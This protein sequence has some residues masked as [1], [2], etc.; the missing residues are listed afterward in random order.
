MRDGCHELDNYTLLSDNEK[1]DAMLLKEIEGRDSRSEIHHGCTHCHCVYFRSQPRI[2]LAISSQ[3]KIM[4]RLAT[5]KNEGKVKITTLGYFTAARDYVLIVCVF[6]TK[7]MYLSCI[8][9]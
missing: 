7:N 2:L 4:Q 3:S 1:R 9:V 5:D 8:I 6:L